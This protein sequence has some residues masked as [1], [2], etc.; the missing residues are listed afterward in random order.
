MSNHIA[1][2]NVAGSGAELYGE[3]MG[4][5]FTE[6]SGEAAARAAATSFES[7]VAVRPHNKSQNRQKQYLGTHY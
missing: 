4:V 5:V 7:P 1:V 3:Y 2:L 6:V